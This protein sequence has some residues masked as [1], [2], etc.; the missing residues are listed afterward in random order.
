MER[1]AWII[2]GIVCV[3]LVSCKKSD[4]RSCWKGHGNDTSLEIPLDSV[5]S[6]RLG[7]GIKY[8]IIQDNQKKLVVKGGENMVKLVQAD[9]DGYELNI[10]NENKC[11]FLRD[12][13]RHIE[14]EIHY[15]VIR[16]IYAE[17]SDSLIFEG[18]F[19]ADTI[20]VELA[21]A[22]G[23]MLMDTQAEYLQI[24]VAIG[25]GDYILSGY[26]KHAE[27]KCQ[28]RGFA[29]A[30]NFT[31]KSVFVYQNSTADM[32]VNLDSTSALVVIDGTG[33]VYAKGNP[34]LLTT[35][36][37]GSGKLIQY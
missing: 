28:D 18:K 35:D 25:T 5:N 8:R 12:A 26:A 32:F 9:Y 14:V 4:E 7:K 11:H 6:W 13:E 19:N 15:P 20:R 30:S 17:P 36:I 10:H 34:G 3:I 21:F 27:V 24:V 1:I 29:D 33:D 23:T 37:I 2:I 16:K 22:G 31:A